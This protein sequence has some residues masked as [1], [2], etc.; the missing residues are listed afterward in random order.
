[1]RIQIL[2][3]GLA[4]QIRHYIFVRFAERSRPGDTWF[5]D[6]SSFFS[7]YILWAQYQLEKV[8]GLKLNL[9]SN[10]YDKTTWQEIIRRK[11]TGIST[12]QILYDL[13][14]PVVM[15][16]GRLFVDQ[17]PFS[18]KIIVPN[19]PHLG[20]HPEYL[21]QPYENVYYHAEWA[22]KKWFS[23]YEEENLRELTF[24]VLSDKRNLEYADSIRGCMS[25]GIHV[26]RGD[27]VDHGYDLPP[28]SYKKG[29][30]AVL[31]RFPD[32]RFFVFSD[33][34]DWCRQHEEEL[35]FRLAAHITYVE[36]NRT[37]YDYIDMQLLSM[38]RGIVRNE[39]SSFSQVA[40]WLDRN[41]EIEIKI[42]GVSKEQL[43]AVGAVSDCIDELKI[44]NYR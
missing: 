4:N 17:E 32:A 31:E 16:E 10:Y 37:P 3:G 14:M 5:F 38:C 11:K 33:D 18:G 13:G 24:P 21:E 28:A 39:I 23:A 15:F 2:E 44:I 1:M 42:R 7:H 29:C 12:V 8:F 26:R 43:N 19:Y 27:F 30:M 22:S 41:L 9:L 25:I 35:G 36:G 34:L 6:D 20:F 40:G